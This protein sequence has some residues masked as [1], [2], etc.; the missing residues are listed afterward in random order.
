MCGIFGAIGAGLSNQERNNVVTLGILNQLRGKDSTGI[1]V[2]GRQPKNYQKLRSLVYKDAVDSTYFFDDPKTKGLLSGDLFGC[3]AIIGHCRS[4]THGHVTTANAH[5][6]IVQNGT[7]I[8]VHNGTISRFRP[9]EADMDTRTDSLK[10]YELIAEKG[11]DEALAD[12]GSDAAF[13]LVW[14]DA[15]N[16][17]L[18][19]ARN[20]RRPLFVMRGYGGTTYFASEYRQLEFM[21]YGADSG[22]LSKHNEEPDIRLVEVDYHYTFDVRQPSRW[23]KRQ[24]TYKTLLEERM[25]NAASSTSP[26][27]RGGGFLGG[28]AWESSF[29]DATKDEP[30]AEEEV[31]ETTEVTDERPVIA[32]LPAP[33]T[34]KESGVAEAVEETFRRSSTGASGTSTV[35]TKAMLP[36]PGGAGTVAPEVIVDPLFS[37][38][39][40]IEPKVVG[41]TT[42][43]HQEMDTARVPRSYVF[44]DGRVFQRTGSTNRK[45]KK[46]R[47]FCIP[48][49]SDPT[50]GI[51]RAV[52]EWEKL[53]A[54][55][56]THAGATTIQL[57]RSAFPTVIESYPSAITDEKKDTY[58]FLYYRGPYG[59][60][61][62]SR[63]AKLLDTLAL[64]CVVTG[65]VPDINNTVFWF[66]DDEFIIDTARQ[67]GHFKAYNA[68]RDMEFVKSEL[69]YVT[70]EYAADYNIKRVAKITTLHLN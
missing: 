52:Y 46:G 30:K 40:I 19:M 51:P 69:V 68:G 25:R 61:I 37:V 17:T 12:A 47:V 23:E 33:E 6:Y 39:R 62:P 35:P 55:V 18:N 59:L 38:R 50:A 60:M 32:R 24:L 13:A 4:A 7:V 14:Y 20:E 21:A 26:G 56:V 9:N 70:D 58:K 27:R 34:V 45:T 53:L 3:G 28:L 8:G 16:G 1:V 43:V 31:Q 41:P 64:G 5:P 11:I 66:S 54:K 49:L 29:E 44:Q 57:A 42:K 63:N 10:L 15:R 65:V 36:R 48:S 2:I 22:L 67:D